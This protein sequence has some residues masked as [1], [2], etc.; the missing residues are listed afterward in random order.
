[1]F[2][3]VKEVE[4]KTCY[5]KL[6]NKPYKAHKVFIVARYNVIGKLYFHQCEEIGDK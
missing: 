4:R 2:N 6:I 3:E 1:M 5:K